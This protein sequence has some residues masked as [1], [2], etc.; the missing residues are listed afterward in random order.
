[1]LKIGTFARLTGTTIKA[2]RFYER[3]GLIRP[4]YVDGATGYRYFDAAQ[5]ADVAFVRR[6]RRVGFTVREIQIVIAGSATSQRLHDALAARQKAVSGEIH[7]ASEQLLEV[8]AW[9]ARLEAGDDDAPTVMLRSEPPMT[10]AWIRRAVASYAQAEDL[11]DEFRASL[12][13]STHA[14]PPSAIWHTCGDAGEP[15]LCEAYAAIDDR[16]RVR[17][18]ARV[19]PR[20]GELLATLLH[21]GPTTPTPR[22]YDVLR[23]WISSQGL[24]IAGPKREVYWQGTPD[25]ERASDLTEIQFPVERLG[26][27]S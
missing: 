25:V 18:P 3:Q 26:R 24:R 6:L 4:A 19:R 27:V 16:A 22:P 5:I 14:Q 20:P 15:A 10:V 23:S 7:R 12:E 17:P 9:I 11:F 8:R 13:R 2:L 21:R 1:M